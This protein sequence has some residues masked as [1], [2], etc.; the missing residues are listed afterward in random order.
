[1]VAIVI[2]IFVGHALAQLNASFS[3]IA[4]KIGSWGG[5]ITTLSIWLARQVDRGK[6]ALAQLESLYSRLRQIREQRMLESE[7]GPRGEVEN[8]RQREQA[9]LK[10]VGE[11]DLKIQTLECELAELKPGRRLQRFIQ[12]RSRAADYKQH[13]G[14]VSLIR[15]DFMTLSNFLSKR[16]N[17]P[18]Q[19]IVLYI[20][21]L[22]RCPPERV[23]EVLEAIHLL[24]AFKLFV[25][26]VGVDVRWVSRSLLGRYRNLLLDDSQ[27]G[28]DP[29]ASP[30]DY[31]EKIF[32]IPFWIRP[33][34]AKGSEELLAGLLENPEVDGTEGHRVG[35]GQAAPKDSEV[36]NPSDNISYSAMDQAVPTEPAPQHG[37]STTIS[38]TP[39]PVSDANPRQKE[40]ETILKRLSIEPAELD[41]MK[42]LAQFVG[43][44]PRRIKRFVNIYRLLKASV[45]TDELASFFV[46]GSHSEEYQVALVLLAI[47]TG[48]PELAPTVL[49]QIREAD[50]NATV[51]EFRMTLKQNEAAS[52]NG[53][54]TRVMAILEYYQQKKGTQVTLRDL[55]RWV[56]LAARYSFRSCT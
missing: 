43:T 9:A 27:S 1:L 13:L 16:G 24:L 45:P 56:P 11:V 47:L 54:N 32:Q 41:F 17:L 15:Q 4:A 5:L 10:K 38:Q 26:V 44:S 20:D 33:M 28:R 18:I 51:E 6:G 39:S 7:A 55:K 19:R 29:L 48:S 22:D 30:H 34:D 40:K 21:D 50:G 37:S 23:V 25:V 53:D 12:E 42:G 46:S 36:A 2:P 52:G 49:R 14:L 35:V 3:D 8:L 31:M